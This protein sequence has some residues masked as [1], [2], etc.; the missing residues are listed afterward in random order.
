M[1][2][3]EAHSPKYNADGSIDLTVL[4]EQIGAEI[5]FTATENDT[6]EHGR[7]LFNSAK[8]GAYGAIE[9]YIEPTL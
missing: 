9:P 2:I 5:P 7:I 8:Q 1:K 3:I 6:E 4:F